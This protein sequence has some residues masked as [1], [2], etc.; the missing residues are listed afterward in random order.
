MKEAIPMSSSRPPC[1]HEPR[2]FA[3]DRA[4]RRACALLLLAI[5]LPV[6]AAQAGG[7]Y[8]NEFSTTSQGN[9]GAGRGAWVPDASA[10]LHNPASMTRLDDHGLAAGASVIFGRVRFDPS[11]ASPNGTGRGG[12]QAHP[13]LVPSFSYAHK[14]S[15]RV[16]IGLSVFA[17]AGAALDPSNGWAGRFEVTD[18]ALTVLTISPTI[19]V[20]VTDWLS[21][22]GGPAASYARLDWDLR[23]PPALAGGP[24]RQLRL[25]ELDDWEATGR[26]GVLLE[27]TDALSISVYYNA[28]TDF[29]LRGQTRGPLG[30]NPNLSTDLPFPQFVEVSA[31]YQVN[32]RLALLGTFNWEDWSTADD[33][34]L[35]LGAQTI[36]A[37]TGFDD[38]YKIGIGANYR[39]REDWLLQTGIMFDT[40]GLQN[41]S[42]TTAL[43]V[44]QQIR[45]SL[46]FQHDLN[47]SLTLGASFTY[48]NLGD[49]EVRTANVVG[50]YDENDL[51][52]LGFTVA[53]KRLPWS[54]KLTF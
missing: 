52:I 44:D 49:S 42:R 1:S 14:A 31:Y 5:L 41:K 40:S 2:R 47:D 3:Y 39:I 33:L 30:L 36:P 26:V 8:L 19:A 48:A 54:G 17:E 20:R 13:A 29:K 18:L 37:T 7:L 24:E 10:T 4:V 27:P 45:F 35:G 21:V 11:P 23:V 22:G 43:P 32:E 34:Q 15:D 9:A 25:E 6:G 28:E 12:N 46:G 50:D 53:F 51:Y 38:T 16:R